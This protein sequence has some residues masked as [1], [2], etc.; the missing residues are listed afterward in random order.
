LKFRF[1]WT[2]WSVDNTGQLHRSNLFLG[3][4]SGLTPWFQA[5]FAYSDAGHF[6]GRLPQLQSRQTHRKDVTNINPVLVRAM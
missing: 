5:T 2:K 4:N 1:R 6:E 3:R